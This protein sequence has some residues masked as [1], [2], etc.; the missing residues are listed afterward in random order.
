MHPAA[1]G[2]DDVVAV[3]AIAG[4]R[5]GELAAGAVPALA[6]PGRRAAQDRPAGGAQGGVRVPGGGG[7]DPDDARRGARRPDHQRV[8]GVGDDGRAG[9]AG[10]LQRDPPG[11]SERL[12]LVVPVELVAAEVQQHQDLGTA[13]GDHVGHHALVGLEH[14]D[15]GRRPLAQRRRDA[16]VQ[17]GA[18]GVGDQPVGVARPARPRTAAASRWVVVVLPLVPDTASTRRPCSS[19]AKASGA[20]RVSTWPRMDAPEPWPARREASAAT[21]PSQVAASSR[22]RSLRGSAGGRRGV[23]EVRGHGPILPRPSRPRHCPPSGAGSTV[24]YCGSFGR[25]ADARAGAADPATEPRRKVLAA[26]GEVPVELL[27]RDSS[28]ARRQ[29]S[30][31]SRVVRL[32]SERDEGRL[33]HPLRGRGVEVDAGPRATCASRA[34][35]AGSR[36]R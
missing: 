12:D 35:S 4:L 27:A 20:S 24:T 34:G 11:A 36:R 30:R 19:C 21:L 18:V 17:V 8:V 25:P 28:A 9:L 5:L 29:R 10:A 2:Q 7:V 16:V 1:V 23:G 14:G 31:P 33:G 32:Q 15:V 6:V 22:S 26:P 13:V 3:D